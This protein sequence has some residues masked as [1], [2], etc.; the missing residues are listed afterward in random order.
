MEQTQLTE[1][2]KPSEQAASHLPC[3]DLSIHDPQGE[4][5]SSALPTTDLEAV[6]WHVTHKARRHQRLAARCIYAMSAFTV[7]FTYLLYWLIDRYGD[8]ASFWTHQYP[9]LLTI[10][11]ACLFGS[12]A[13]ILRGSRKTGR[14]VRSHADL[15]SDQPDKQSIEALID[16]FR[17]DDLHA[18]HRAKSALTDLLPTL[19]E[20]DAPLL[21]TPS[22]AVLNRILRSPSFDPGFKDVRE[23]FVDTA[24]R[25]T[26]LRLAI[27]RAYCHVGGA[28][29]LSIIE[30]LANSAARVEA[31]L[32]IKE[33]ASEHLPILR[34]RVEQ[35]TEQ[36]SLLRASAGAPVNEATLLRAASATPITVPDELL[37]PAES[38]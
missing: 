34:Q 23:L 9:I 12:A 38:S 32:V 4:T 26:R 15:L 5:E 17:F 35:L 33:A 2:E 16:L 20:E 8:S 18:H 25:D 14:V 13:G 37:R 19:C 24:E 1:H 6:R 29:E 27:M 7:A 3:G 28:E 36:K 10:N 22:R 31:D 21:T 30:K 11:L